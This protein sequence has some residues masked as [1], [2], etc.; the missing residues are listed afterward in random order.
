MQRGKQIRLFY[1]S[2]QHNGIVRAELLNWTGYAYSAPRSA[3]H[4]L[5]AKDDAKGA[6]VYFLLCKSD[7][8]EDRFQVYVGETMNGIS[9]MD[10]HDEKTTLTKTHCSYLE[11]RL[12]QIIKQ[13]TAY[14]FDNKKPLND[15]TG[16][17]SDAD[18]SDMETF[19]D[20]LR[21]VL[22][23]LGCQVL[24]PIANKPANTSEQYLSPIEEEF[25]LKNSDGKVYATAYIRDGIFIVRAG[26]KGKFEFSPS[27]YGSIRKNRE[28]LIEKKKIVL[29]G[30]LV[31]L[32]E[33][34]PFTSSS[35]P[36]TM[37]MGAPVSGPQNWVVKSSPN[38]T[39]KQW[40]ASRTN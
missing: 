30:D 9:R 36:A 1:V 33:D 40:E 22:P 39:Y 17:L 6:G 5:G 4:L 8:Q 14:K 20:N 29:E 10:D 25:L 7:E 16:R 12:Y 11:Y 34:I 27:V 38:M 32:T 31:V 15:Y 2:G 23:A 35:T 3:L 18:I 28:T 21:F 26:S 19:I 13:E 24:S 37:L